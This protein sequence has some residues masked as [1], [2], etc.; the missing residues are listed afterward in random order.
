MRQPE[1]MGSI[2]E[3][4]E[5]FYKTKNKKD[6]DIFMGHVTQVVR[7]FVNQKC[8]GSRWDPDELYSI[9][10]SDMW[11]L[12]QRWAPQEGKKF[13]WLMLKQLR[14]K[15]INFIHC[16]E[17][18][19]HKI[20]PTCGARQNTSKVNCEVCNS[21]LKISDKVLKEATEKTNSFDYLE[22]FANKELINKLLKSLEDDPR[23]L[24]IVQLLLEGYSKGDIS[25]QIGI[26]Q[27][28]INNRI[29]KCKKIVDKLCRNYER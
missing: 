5:N 25:K 19:P 6:A 3:A 17:G 24:K 12:L 18:N 29:S 9:L 23:T 15:T 2:D 16:V 11:R 10:L 21:S 8:T 26:A 28:A 13:H 22:D 4:A 27:N 20:C 14:N 1:I 7:K